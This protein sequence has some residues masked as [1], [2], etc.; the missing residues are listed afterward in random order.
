MRKE[1]TLAARPGLSATAHGGRE[2]PSVGWLGRWRLGCEE[3]KLVCGALALLGRAELESGAGLRG[4]ARPSDLGRL[5]EREA[6]RPKE[7]EREL[8]FFLNFP[9]HFQ[10][11]FKSF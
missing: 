4:E 5:R 7:R 3:R 11:H 1:T 8:H 9:S 2:R 10:K 6:S